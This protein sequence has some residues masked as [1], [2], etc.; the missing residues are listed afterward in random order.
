VSRVRS[1]LI[2]LAVSCCLPLRVELS[3]VLLILS[4]LFCCGL[5]YG[6][7][8]IVLELPDQKARG[9]LVSRAFKRLLPEHV[10]KV[11]GEIPVTT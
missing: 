9:F 3:H 1:A 11:F 2:F 8:G 5:L 7:A 10:Y 6:E 4:Y